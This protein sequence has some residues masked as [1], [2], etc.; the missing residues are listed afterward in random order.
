METTDQRQLDAKALRYMSENA[1]V[2]HTMLTPFRWLMG[3][4]KIIIYTLL[5]LSWFLYT[6]CGWVANVGEYSLENRR[7]AVCDARAYLHLCNQYEFDSTHPHRDYQ[8]NLGSDA[9][10][11]RSAPAA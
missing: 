8:W 9:D 6:L 4:G 7:E 10:D 11:I 3:L 5:L 2:E 1:E